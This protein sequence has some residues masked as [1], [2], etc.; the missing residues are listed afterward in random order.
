MPK[1]DSANIFQPL[2]SDLFV[3]IN[4]PSKAKEEVEKATIYKLGE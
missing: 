2:G 4:L 3:I 1:T